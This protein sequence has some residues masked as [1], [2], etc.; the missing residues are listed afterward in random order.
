[1]QANTIL[2]DS[3]S[4]N[5]HNWQVTTHGPQQYF[6][7]DNAY[8]IANN[9]TKALALALL[10][11]ET[12]NGSYVYSLTMEAISGDE[13]AI[14]NQ[15][16]LVF[17]FS[18][19]QKNGKTSKSFYIFEVAN[20]KGGTYQLLKYDDSGDPTMSP[21]TTLWS[22]HY[23]NEFHFGHGP[24]SVNTFKVAINAGK[25]TLIVNNKAVGNAQDTSLKSG[26]VGMLVNLNKTEVA[27]SKLLLTYK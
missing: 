2:S 27:F 23:G 15:F 4:A 26:L 22:A 14:T 16:G 11:D 18:V 17:N 21:W 3:L 5:S 9:D 6:F 20:T 25:F 8:H 12:V 24:K 10:P 1:M 13:T 7:K 19:S